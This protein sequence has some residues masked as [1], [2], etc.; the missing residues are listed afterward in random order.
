[1]NFAVIKNVAIKSFY[2]MDSEAKIPLTEAPFGSH[3]QMTG[4]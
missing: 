1:M 4:A 2:Y 3:L